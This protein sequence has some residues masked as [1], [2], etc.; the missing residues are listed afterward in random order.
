MAYPDRIIPGKREVGLA[1]RLPLEGLE[2]VEALVDNP[3]LAR[4]QRPTF[5][6]LGVRKW[7]GPFNLHR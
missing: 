7:L 5:V 3:C 6:S 4:S 1:M 2:R